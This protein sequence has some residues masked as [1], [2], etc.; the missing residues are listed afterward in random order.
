MKN[1]MKLI[2]L[3]VGI[4]IGMLIATSSQP[5]INA[6]PTV[7]AQV[8]YEGGE[9]TGFSVL[10]WGTI[11]KSSAAFGEVSTTNGYA[12]NI[13]S[14]ADCYLC[15][16]S[17]AAD[18]LTNFLA[19]KYVELNMGDDFTIPAYQTQSGGVKVYLRAQVDVATTYQGVK[20]KIK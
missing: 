14:N 2:M 18:A 7:S 16:G 9:V 19:G 4:F 15:T 11:P 6:S 12:Y 20:L 17:S 1:R 8:S 5:S 13:F 3:I 10:E